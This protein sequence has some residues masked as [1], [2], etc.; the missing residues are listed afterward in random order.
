MSKY[1]LFIIIIF[2]LNNINLFAKDKDP[3][4]IVDLKK[5]GFYKPIEEFPESLKKKF[6][7]C[8]VIDC[9]LILFIHE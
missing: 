1:F 6:V 3:V 5:L 4:D 7:S 2:F 9:K 8:L